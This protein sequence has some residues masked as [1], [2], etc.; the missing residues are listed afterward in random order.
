M[1]KRYSPDPELEY[2]PYLNEGSE[3]IDHFLERL[4]RPKRGKRCRLTTSSVGDFNLFGTRTDAPVLVFGPG[5]GDIHAP[6]EYV[7]RDEVVA[8]TDHLLDFLVDVYSGQ[9]GHM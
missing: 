7:N 5:G 6:N 4:P 3:Y 2:L 1:A 8:T 9:D